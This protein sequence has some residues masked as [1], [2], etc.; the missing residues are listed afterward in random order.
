VTI[1]KLTENDRILQLLPMKWSNLAHAEK[2][3]LKLTLSCLAHGLLLFFVSGCVNAPQTSEVQPKVTEG[4]QVAQ[5]HVQA[6]NQPTAKVD[7]M[8]DD[9]KAQYEHGHLEAAERTLQTLLDLDPNNQRALYYLG[10]VARQT[11][12]QAH[13]DQ[14]RTQ[15]PPEHLPEPPAYPA[16]PRLLDQSN[17][18][19]AVLKDFRRVSGEYAYANMESLLNHIGRIPTVD[20][21]IIRLEFF[22]GFAAQVYLNSE[23]YNYVLDQERHWSIVG[24]GSWVPAN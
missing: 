11:W 13:P 20:H 5:R 16:L 21:E 19:P 15:P 9:A 4:L 10:L 17:A 8:L 2:P 24:G 6:A 22:H 7:A 14:R 18:K 23:Y 1:W 12:V 3:H